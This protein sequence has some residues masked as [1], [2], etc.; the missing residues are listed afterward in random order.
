MLEVFFT[1]LFIA[2]ALCSVAMV[3]LMLLTLKWEL[4]FRASTCV[5]IGVAVYVRS[6]F[7]LPLPALSGKGGQIVQNTVLAIQT[8]TQEIVSTAEQFIPVSSSVSITSILFS[9]WLTV[10]L[11]LSIKK[12]ASAYRSVHTS[13]GFRLDHKP[14][15][16]CDLLSQARHDMGVTIPIALCASSSVENVC[17]TGI[18]NAKYTTIYISIPLYTKYKNGGM[19]DQQL[20]L[21]FRHE[22]AHY[23]CRDYLLEFLIELACCVHWFNPLFH[24]FAKWVHTYAEGA[25][26]K[27]ALK[28]QD[29]DAV[30]VMRG[31]F[32]L[33]LQQVRAIEEARRSHRKSR[34]VPDR[35]NFSMIRDISFRKRN[36]DDNRVGFSNFKIFI[37]ISAIVSFTF[38]LNC[39]GLFTQTLNFTNFKFPWERAKTSAAIPGGEISFAY[40][41]SNPTQIFVPSVFERNPDLIINQLLFECN[42]GSDVY[43]PISGEIVAIESVG[44]SRLGNTVTIKNDQL[45]VTIGHLTAFKFAVGDFV[46]QQQLVGTVDNSGKCPAFG[47]EILVTDITGNPINLASLINGY[48]P[49]FV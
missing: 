29:D 47:S 32:D 21:F 14:N 24:T 8:R 28:D 19:T 25:R 5:W 35:H 7:L 6:L 4:L 37:I 36:L 40:P 31:L 38:S 43:A 15:R 30:D 26:D 9:V 17:I 2:S 41:V 3:I 45:V 16:V 33:S 39:T 44:S 46:E 11:V 1:Q 10:F 18:W 13:M 42:I 22:L 12:I 49:I 27:F 34:T 48:V 20:Y 23:I